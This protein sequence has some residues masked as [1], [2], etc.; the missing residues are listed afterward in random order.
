[1][2]KLLEVILENEEIEKIKICDKI[3]TKFKFNY[4]LKITKDNIIFGN[5]IKLYLRTKDNDIMCYYDIFNRIKLDK[6]HI[7][8]KNILYETKIYKNNNLVKSVNLYNIIIDNNKFVND[9][10]YTKYIDINKKQEDYYIIQMQN[11]A[12]DLLFE[13]NKIYYFKSDL[14]AEDKINIKIINNKLFIFG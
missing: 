5:D 2:E 14:Y 3:K 12:I 7:Y 8:K 1:M 11:C 9:K 10:I 13:N 6:I 4:N